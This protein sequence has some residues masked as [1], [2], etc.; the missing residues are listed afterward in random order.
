MH[1]LEPD[2]LSRERECGAQARAV[3]AHR[4]RVVADMGG[5]V[6]AVVGCVAYAADTGSDRGTDVGG[7]GPVGGDEL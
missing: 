4:C 2:R 6:E 5:E 3:L 7:R 1:L